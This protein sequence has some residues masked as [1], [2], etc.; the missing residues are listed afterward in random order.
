M[1]SRL[2]PSLLVATLSLLVYLNSL[3]GD[4]VFDDHR[5]ILTNDDLDVEKT[6]LWE[7][8]VHDFW[9]GAMSRKESHKSYR[10]LTVVTFRYLNH[11]F[12]GLRPYSYHA[13]NVALHAACSLLYLEVCRVLLAGSEA[14]ATA[15]A[16]SFAAHAVH[17]EAVSSLFSFCFLVFFS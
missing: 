5:A 1:S 7:L 8:F 6:T 13:V 11:Y 3:D 9:G 2:A 14:W 4:F 15:A 16:C 10:P 17:T 12:S